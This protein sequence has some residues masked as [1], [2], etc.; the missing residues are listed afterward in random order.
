MRTCYFT[1]QK[2]IYEGVDYDLEESKTE[3]QPQRGFLEES[4]EKGKARNFFR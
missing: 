3:E 2:D 1:E 4:V